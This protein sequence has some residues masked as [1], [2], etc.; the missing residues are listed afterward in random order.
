M[1]LIYTERD[2][3]FIA[4]VPRRSFVFGVAALLS[5][6]AIPGPLFLN[7]LDNR[8]ILCYHIYMKYKSTYNKEELISRWDEI[9]SPARFAGANAELDWVYN[10]FRKG[11]KVKLVKKPRASYDP[12]ATV[13]RG[14]IETAKNGS[15]IRGVY[16]K[17]LFDYIITAAVG[18]VYFGVCAEYLSRAQDRTLPLMLISFGVIAVLFALIPFPGKRRKYG[19]LIREVTGDP[20]GKKQNAEKT[21]GGG[22]ENKEKEKY[23]FRVS[24][25]RK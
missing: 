24:G 14:K 6:D 25:R 4:S 12:Y 7:L 21:D 11:D 3:C 1:F 9:T 19:A 15:Q 20:P 13:F 18:A 2:T 16:T 17:G 10:S 23:K 22:T 8:F 5:F